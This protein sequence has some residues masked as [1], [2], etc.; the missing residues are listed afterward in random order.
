M[1]KCVSCNQVNQA[2]KQKISYARKGASSLIQTLFVAN[3]VLIKE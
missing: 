3:L 1:V 2:K